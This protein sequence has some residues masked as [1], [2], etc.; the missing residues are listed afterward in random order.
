MPQRYAETAEKKMNVFVYPICKQELVIVEGI[1][2]TQLFMII[3][4]IRCVCPRS[5]R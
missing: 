2:T 5:L 3:S 4:A 1:L